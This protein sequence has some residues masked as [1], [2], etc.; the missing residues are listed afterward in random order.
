MGSSIQDVAPAIQRTWVDFGAS[1]S[2]AARAEWFTLWQDVLT[3]FQAAG[4]SPA[5]IQACREFLGLFERH[6]DLLCPI[7]P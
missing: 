7:G 5:E 1:G 2:R 3:E 6:A 4:W